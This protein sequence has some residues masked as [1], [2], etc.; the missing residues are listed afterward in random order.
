MGGQDDEGNFYCA[1]FVR[2]RQ[3]ELLNKSGFPASPNGIS[4]TR[5]CGQRII[6]GSM[7]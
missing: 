4:A 5:V 3:S 6:P 1:I 2:N 7:Q